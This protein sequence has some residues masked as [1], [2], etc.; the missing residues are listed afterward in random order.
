MTDLSLS[1]ARWW[2]LLLWP[3]ALGMAWW[4]QRNSQPA[5]PLLV[6]RALLALRMVLWTLLLFLLCGPR[7]AWNDVERQ[8]ATLAVLLD[9]S[10]S[11]VH[12]EGRLDHGDWLPALQNA[13]PDMRVR[14]FAY[15][16]LLRELDDQE[17]PILP[18]TGVETDLDAA[19]AGVER[20]LAGEHWTGLVV[21][22]DGNITRGDWPL[23]RAKALPARIWTAGTGR[24]DPVADALV[25]QMDLNRRVR[26][27][28]VQPVEVE[29]EG[30]GLNGRKARLLLLEEGVE[31]AAVDF[32]LGADGG[33]RRLALEWK[34]ERVGPR[35]LEAVLQVEGGG[36]R[37][38][39]NN[40][41]KVQVMVD[42]GRLPVLLL[43]GRPSEDLAFLRQVLEAREDLELFFAMPERPGTDPADLRAAVDKAALLV[44]A[45]W[46]L[47]GR[48]S[49]DMIARVAARAGRVPM[50]V[51]DGAGLD[52]GALQP[53]LA[54]AL[55]PWQTASEGAA[56]VPALDPL[57]GPEENLGELRS[58]YS[59]MPPLIATRGQEKSNALPAGSRALLESAQGHPLIL[60]QERAG[61][62][63]GW[64]L[65]QGLWRWGVGSQLSLGHNRRALELGDRL[66]GWV[67]AAP[68]QGL[69]DVQPD[70][71]ILPVG[72]PLAFDAR[73]REEDGRSRE[74]A[75]VRLVLVSDSLETHVDLADLGGGTYRGEVSALAPGTWS[76][77]AE[78]RQGDRPVVADSGRV[79]VED[80]SPESLDASRH[81][82]LLLELASVGGGRALDL[83][84]QE[85]RRRLADASALDS[86][87]MRPLLRRVG[88]Q[89]ELAAEGWI[90]AVS[91]LLLAGEWIWRRLHGM[92]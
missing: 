25:R 26:K 11:M 33:R 78:A 10:A 71:D 54:R 5:P 80:R 48:G 91:I 79:L 18:G 1:L 2:P 41:R 53:A 14:R 59:E 85:D 60:L 15:D 31:R 87:E 49:R 83:D 16:G 63:Q 55:G 68:G 89:R 50:L 7:L 51:L 77:R 58:V 65:M 17:K 36:E 39:E 69:L 27:G 34:A 56:R 61:L 52:L 4:S 19:L 8:P 92:L 40:R 23:E 24:L 86:L 6:S 30:R 67:L 57:L 84:R 62:R 37:T 42:E 13:L 72:A 43:A 32:V 47:A 64:I 74:G 90:L 76:W 20:A 45:Q 70:R 9:N 29:V 73:L 3:L 66:V 12:L 35:A 44:L 46:P 38:L 28:Q 21:V 81:P 82:R 22:G 75:A 88:R